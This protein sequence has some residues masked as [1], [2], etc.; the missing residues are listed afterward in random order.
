MRQLLAAAAVLLALI[1]PVAAESAVES[2]EA[3]LDSLF[4]ALKDSDP[5]LA[6][7]ITA[8]IQEIWN[9]TGSASMN[10][11]VLRAHRAMEAG[12]AEAA[13]THLNDLVRLAP[14][15]AEGW[16]ARATVH[17]LLG[18]YPESLADI[19]ETLKREPRH[20]GALAGRGLVFTALGR[21]A[22]ALASFEAALA[23]HPHLE[24]PQEMVMMLR[25]QLR[26]KTI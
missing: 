1:T 4:A 13:L 7:Q 5:D 15:F 10:L 25:E 2:R 11:L 21:A 9:D 3:W 23:L 17:Y 12:S 22:E 18:S 6:D 20:F 26:G 16:N 19:R 8:E 14:D 24:G